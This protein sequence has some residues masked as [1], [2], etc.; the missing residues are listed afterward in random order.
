M[1]PFTAF[2]RKSSVMIFFSQYMAQPSFMIWVRRTKSV[3]AWVT[4]L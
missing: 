1:M 3:G 2:S 4:Y